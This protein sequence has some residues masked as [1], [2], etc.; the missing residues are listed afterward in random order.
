MKDYRTED[1]EYIRNEA[2]TLYDSMFSDDEVLDSKKQVY[3]MIFNNIEMIVGCQINGIEN[4]EIDKKEIKDIIKDVVNN[5]ERQLK[6]K[7]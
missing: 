3:A 5:N 2:M 7:K 1:I 6:Y 4:L